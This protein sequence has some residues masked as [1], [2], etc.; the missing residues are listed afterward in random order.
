MLPPVGIEPWP[1][2]NLQ[3]GFKLPLSRFT[4]RK[5]NLAHKYPSKI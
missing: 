1:L 2:M 5:Q 3:D 4:F